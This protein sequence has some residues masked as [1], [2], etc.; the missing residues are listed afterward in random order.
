MRKINYERQTEREREKSLPSSA[1]CMPTR[2]KLTQ[3]RICRLTVLDLD[4]WERYWRVTYECMSFPAKRLAVKKWREFL[5]G[6]N[7][8]FISA[9]VHAQHGR[10]PCKERL[11]TDLVIHFSI[12]LI[13]HGRRVH[14]CVWFATVEEGK[15]QKWRN[16]RKE[17]VYMYVFIAWGGSCRQGNLFKRGELIL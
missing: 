8:R 7:Q 12:W 4:T 10:G 13:K 2:G 1:N 17:S 16:E 5:R 9:E 15:Y 6:K 3:L 11:F 14:N